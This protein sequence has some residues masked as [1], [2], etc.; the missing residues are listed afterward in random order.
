[1]H[2]KRQALTDNTATSGPSKC[3]V[4][5]ELEQLRISCCL[6]RSVR[7]MRLNESR[8]WWDRGNKGLYQGKNAAISV[9]K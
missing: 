1:M 7:Q 6:C 9:Q 8:G 5:E 3:Y 4:W 2:S